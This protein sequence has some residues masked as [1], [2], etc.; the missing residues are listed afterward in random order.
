M[1]PLPPASWD[2]AVLGSPIRLTAHTAMKRPA[3]DVE[4]GEA[5]DNKQPRLDLTNG[6]DEPQE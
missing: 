6:A 5:V 1:S 2:R 3:E 4:E